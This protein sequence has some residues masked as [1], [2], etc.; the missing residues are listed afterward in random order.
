M[1]NDKELAEFA[2]YLLGLDV[3]HEDKKSSIPEL[4]D[5]IYADDMGSY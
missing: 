4:P 3:K 5:G 2:R 1:G